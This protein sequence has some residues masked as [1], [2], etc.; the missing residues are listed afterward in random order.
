MTPNKI[1]NSVRNQLYL[2]ALLKGALLG[3]SGYFSGVTLGLPL[4]WSMLLG[5]V[6]G[7]AGLLLGQVHQPR[8]PAAVT[9]IHRVVGD[10]EYS[11]PLLDKPTLNMAG[12]MQ[13]ERLSARLANARIPTVW[14][15][16]IWPYAL[17]LVGVAGLAYGL[18][19]VSAKNQ[20]VKPKLLTGSRKSVPE[21]P[22]KPPR[23]TSATV[24]VQPSG[25]SGLPVRQT[26]NLNVAALNG[27]QLVWQIRFS[28]NRNLRVRLTNNRGE[29]L[30]FRA[31]NAGFSYADKLLNSGLYSVRAYWKNPGNGQDSLFYQSAF[32]RLE[33]Q[34]DLAPKI[35]PVAKELYRFHSLKDSKQLTV[36]ARIS[37]DFKVQ[38]AFIIA[39]LA[40]GS[41][42]NVKFREVRMPLSPNNF[43]DARLSKTL[44]LKALDFAPG[45]ELYYYW[46]AID[47]RQPEPNFTKSD[48]YFVVYK[49]TSKVDD[50]QLATMAVNIMPEYFRSQ[51]QIIIDTEKLIAKRGK[52]LKE[53]FNSFSNEIGFDQKVLRLK[54]GQY[55]GE[56]FENQIGG[57]SPL[58]DNDAH[59]LDGYMHKHDADPDKVSGSETPRTFA[60]KMAEKAQQAGAQT[61]DGS[62]P[63]GGDASNGDGHHHGGGKPGEGQDPLAALM[64][65][66][67][68]SHDNAETNTFYEQSTRSLLKMALEQMWQSE[69][70]LRLYEPEKALPFEKQALEYLKTAQQKSRAYAKKTG[71]D[72]PPIKE[73]ETRLTGERK[74]VTNRFTQSRTYS[75][76]QVNSLISSV[77]GL[78]DQ[79]KLTADQ[80]LIVQQ[81]S[82]AMVNRPSVSG[83]PNWFVLSGLQELAAGRVLAIRQRQQLKTNLYKAMGNADSQK[84][85]SFGSNAQ[86]ERAFWRNL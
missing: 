56:E 18:P 59:L 53:T 57:H 86:L 5:V 12:Q 84:T 61:P 71:L 11:L 21:E 65:Q 55:L 47:N 39:T 28:D 58:A 45:D 67:V 35:E 33:A 79:P 81:L 73:K 72:P 15:A 50:S 34:P 36:S 85:A 69:L 30:A 54:Y 83:L 4:V 25:Y 64:E 78:L 29:E 1:I 37:D 10:A 76:T 38:Q 52:V 80:R 51:R 13:M 40:R 44:D 8:R 22:P 6:G 62:T 32:Y 70:H 9:L 14:Q 68:H 43:T 63:T 23:F 60:F 77:L 27:S 16:N 66:Y 75:D 19:L 2:N 41:G 82:G 49:D 31:G 26:N 74:N 3:L 46:G 17:A 7:V 20:P 24:R 48:T 42:E